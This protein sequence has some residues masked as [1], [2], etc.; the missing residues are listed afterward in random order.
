MFSSKI[1]CGDC[2][3]YYGPK[4]WHSNSKYRRVIWQC[5]HKFEGE[6]RCRTAHLYERDIHDLFLKVFSQVMDY[7]AS[8]L[9]DCRLAVQ[10]L[11]NQTELEEKQSSL[12]DEMEV[13]GELIRKCV[14][15]NGTKAQNQEEYLQRYERHV[16]RFE[17][18][19]K[20]YKAIEEERSHR[21]DQQN[22]LEAFIATLE[23]QV[24]LPLEF[25]NDLRIAAID[26]VT[27]NAD[28]TLTFTF[29]NGIEITKCI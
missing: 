10:T 20:Q 9:E 27:V 18:L 25:D 29:Q 13:I 8:I 11:C 16:D 28:E 19:K 6:H 17:R 22:V 5:N 3:S 14:E 24:N 21:K 4:V 2:G 12:M 26:H 23:K 1:I 7:R 15:E